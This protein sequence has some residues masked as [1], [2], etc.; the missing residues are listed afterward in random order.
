MFKK[1]GVWVNV[2]PGEVVEL[3]AIVVISEEGMVEVK[4][5]VKEKDPKKEDSPKEVKKKSRKPVRRKPKP[6]S[7]EELKEMTKDQLND[8][9]ALSGLEKVS[10]RMRKDLM[11]RAILRFL[12]RK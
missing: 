5:E 11:I 2:N 7:R 3:P 4:E 12:K 9:A 10:Q 8:Y 6:K 1:D